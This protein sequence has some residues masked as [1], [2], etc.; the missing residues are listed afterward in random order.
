MVFCKGKNCD[1]ILAASGGAMIVKL[2]ASADER[3]VFLSIEILWNLIEKGSHLQVNH[4][5]L[6][7]SCLQ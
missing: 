3:L 1:H 7:Q 4:T 2:L 5:W 6:T